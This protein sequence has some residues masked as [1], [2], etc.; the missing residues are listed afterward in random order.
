M[1]LD[2]LAEVIKEYLSTGEI[3]YNK[4]APSFPSGGIIIN[5]NELS[6]IYKTGKGKAV[7]RGRVECKDNLILITELPYQVYVEP[8]IEQ[9]KN[10][11]LKEEIS[12]ISN[13]LN[14]SNKK[15][16]LIEIECESSQTLVLKQLYAKTDLQKTYNANQFA[17]V[18]KTPKLLNFKEYIDIYLQHNYECIKNEYQFDLEKSI[19]RL[20][21]VEGLTKALED[22]DNII[23]LI[24]SSNSSANAIENLINK[25]Q[26]SQNQAK[27]IIDMKLGRLAK[28]EKV[29]LNQEKEDLLTTINLCNE[30]IGSEEKRKDIYLERFSNFVKKYPNPRKTE[31][32][33]IEEPKEDKE[34]VNVE[35]EK[36]VVIMTE[37]GLIKRVPS[38]SFKIQKRNGA[39]VKTQ[40][41][42]T[43]AIIRTNTIDSLMVFTDKGR[44]YRILVDNIPSGTNSSKGVPIKSLIEMESFENP[45]LIYSIYHDT[46]A[47]YVLFATKNGTVKKT[48]LEEYT[49]TKKGGITA[50]NL[51]ESDELA[52]VSLI[53]EEQLILITKLGKAI[54]FKSTDINP[55]GR[56]T[57]G[58]RGITLDKDD[59]VITALPIRDTNDQIAIFSANGL[60][61]RT[62]MSEFITQGRGGKGII[63]Y[64]PT[65]TT[66]DVIAAVLVS[67]EDSLLISG[68][69]KGIC[70]N[71]KD[72]GVSGRTSIG[73]SVIKEGK[74]A[75]VSK[76]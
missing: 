5:K 48:S 65:A 53:N 28:L 45:V 51:R 54:K 61:K 23:N 32:I 19:K 46:E 24:K 49:K 21:I 75:E 7:V 47:K 17:L 64:K 39:G 58:L 3:D 66:G 72:I 4:L 25:Y 36:C 69:S 44:M 60:A 14:K 1:C 55:S 71:A 20:E 29:E 50:I 59:E 35:P 27:A 18:G 12:G 42:I 16:L 10:L 63:C 37:S 6:E 9:V 57:I 11:V 41:G 2:E 22:I 34:I 56:A 38:S 43:S 70:I 67:E 68:N 8:F 15:Q 33:Q 26:F 40:D 73:V 52:S 30:I 13:I 76:I 62:N 31:L 74:I